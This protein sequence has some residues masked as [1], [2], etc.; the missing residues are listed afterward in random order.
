MRALSVIVLAYGEEPLLA[1]CVA[2]VLDSEGVE[3]EVLVVDN[4]ARRLP[5]FDDP[6]VRLL[7]PGTNT[8]FAGGCNLAANEATF[9]TL[10]FVNSDLLVDAPALRALVERLDDQDVGLV[11]GS[12]VLPGEPLTINSVGNP[13]HFLMFSWAGAYGELFEDH[14]ADER[15]AGISGALFACRREH[16]RRL[17]GFDTTLFAYCEDADLSLRTWQGGRSVVYEPSAVGVHHYSFTKDNHKWFLLER[18]RLILLCTLYSRRATWWLV[19]VLVPVEV[20]ILVSAWRGGWAREKLRSWRWLLSHRAYLRE[21]RARLRAAPRDPAWTRV[22]EGEINIPPRFGL[23]TPGP[24]NL[25][26]GRYWRLVRRH[27]V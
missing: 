14:A 8:G 20:G 1:E 6:R 21:R 18:N 10:A 4:G 15:V 11:T 26:L 7:S 24:V 12:V 16:W 19:P 5:D 13:I 25:V 17:G 2:A 22:L 9:D 3:L 27:L 23:R